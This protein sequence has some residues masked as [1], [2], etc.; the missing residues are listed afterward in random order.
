L[1]DQF[2]QARR[3][4]P[5]AGRY[6]RT[7]D[8][9][10]KLKDFADAASKADFLQ[11]VLTLMENDLFTADTA[12]LTADQVLQKEALEAMRQNG[13]LHYAYVSAVVIGLHYTIPGDTA[14]VYYN[15][16]EVLG[17][18][19]F[20]EVFR[21]ILVR[22]DEVKEVALKT[23]HTLDRSAEHELLVSRHMLDLQNQ[24]G[25]GYPK[26]LIRV[27]GINV[28]RNSSGAIESAA[29]AQELVTPPTGKGLQLSEFTFDNQA[30][31]EQVAIDLL[32]AVNDLHELG[33]VSSDLKPE[34]VGMRQ[35]ADGSVSPIILDPGSWLLT[36][37][38]A[39]T[40]NVPS[41]VPV[42]SGTLTEV[43]QTEDGEVRTR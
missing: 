42:R 39:G 14:R 37:V 35:N 4:N 24:L 7:V 28:I 43:Y 30:Q 34:N 21:S 9:S 25:D 17:R 41:S 22:G 16:E 12:D 8:I 2:N 23:F 1:I 6:F 13:K 38:P 20:G 3:D 10:A 32:Q 31:A 18:G 27:E 19:S 36:G 5:A 40:P 33:F 11:E 26:G 15:P 29:I